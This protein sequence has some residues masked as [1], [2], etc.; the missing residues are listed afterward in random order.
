M[1]KLIN[2]HQADILAERYLDIILSDIGN[3]LL[4]LI[5]AP[6]IALAI[7]L[8][9]YEIGQPTDSLYYIMLVSCVWFGCINGSKEIVKERA[10][11]RR[12]RM[13]GLNTFAYVFSKIKVLSI[14]SF[15]QCLLF[16]T[17]IHFYI[18]QK[19]NII[20]IFIILFLCTLCGVSL[21]LLL[22]TIVD[23]PDKAV[24]LAP[25]I[26]IPQIL[27]SKMV[28]PENYLRGWAAIVEKL[29]IVKWGFESIQE[30]AGRN[31]HLF[32]LLKGIGILI[33]FCLIYFF[34]TLMLLKFNKFREE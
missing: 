10:I 17:T 23:T 5:Q 30:I 34:I 8:G 31:I 14:V 4:L 9:W 28:I 18:P 33:L 20:L 27:F 24:A 21:G 13:F 1:K 11:Y 6:L 7:S 12:E 29:M 3:T 25:V 22:S 19:G 16:L 32:T 2:W 26:T 15:V